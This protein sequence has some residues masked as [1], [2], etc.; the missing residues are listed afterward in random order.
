MKKPSGITT[1]ITSIVY[2]H[3][4]R[5]NSEDYISYTKDELFDAVRENIDSSD[6][7]TFELADQAVNFIDWNFLIELIEEEF[8]EIHCKYCRE[9]RD[10][11][12]NGYCSR[13]CE[14]LHKAELNER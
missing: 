1:Y 14:R 12:S 9:S 10:L 2:A 3:I 5:D 4:F 11:E 8:Y 7:L 13:S 6:D